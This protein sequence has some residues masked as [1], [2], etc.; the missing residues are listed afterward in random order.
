M[1]ESK[2]NANSRRILERKQL[3][4]TESA[5]HEGSNQIA[6]AEVNIING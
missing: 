1:K 3:R 6:N 4:N 2:M 5:D